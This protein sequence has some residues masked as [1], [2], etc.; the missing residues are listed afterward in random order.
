MGEKAVPEIYHHKYSYSVN[1]YVDRITCRCHWQA[2][3][4]KP[5]YTLIS[6]NSNK[7]LIYPIT[8]CDLLIGQLSERQIDKTTFTESPNT[9]NSKDIQ[10]HN[11]RRC[12]T[13]IIYCNWNN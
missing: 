1:A 8:F 6:L 2:I 12:D 13:E 7:Q 3:Q 10:Q 4:F 5:I 11:T 9:L